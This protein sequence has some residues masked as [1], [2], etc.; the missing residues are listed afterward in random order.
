MLQFSLLVALA[1]HS[2]Q[3]HLLLYSCLILEILY[4]HAGV[5]VSVAMERRSST[6][7]GMFRSLAEGSSLSGG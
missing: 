7:N 1:C 5:V 4:S 3:P 6:G 2:D